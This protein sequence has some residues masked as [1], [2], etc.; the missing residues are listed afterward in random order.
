MQPMFIEQLSDELYRALKDSQP[1]APLT[2]RVPSLTLQD[3]YAIQ[4]RVL[5]HRV[6][7]DGERVIGK[8]IGVTSQVVM[9]LLKV[10]QPDFGH[11]TS[12]M[13]REDGAAIAINELIAPKAEGEIAFILKHELAGPGVTVA[14]VLRATEYVMPCFEIVDSR[15]RDWK[16]QIQDTVADNASSS[17]FILGD[18][19]VDPRE[20]DLSLVGMTLELNGE[21]VSTGAGAAALGHPANAVAWLANTLGTL[22]MTLKPGEVILSGSLGAMVAVKAGDNLRMSIGG[23][24]SAGVRFI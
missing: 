13:L 11:L 19:A 15:I 24:G 8:K 14:D 6:E 10:D 17:L 3:A 5:A 12:A 9:D 21:I 22:D 20:L 18:C 16:I 4:M 23:I 2:E 7:I 1:I